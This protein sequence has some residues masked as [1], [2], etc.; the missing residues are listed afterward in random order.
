VLTSDTKVKL[1]WNDDDECATELAKDGCGYRTY[2]HPLCQ[3]IWQFLWVSKDSRLLVA[4]KEA[5]GLALLDDP[6]TTPVL[7]DW[8]SHIQA[9]LEEDDL[10]TALSGEG[11]DSAYLTASS[12]ELD[13][14]VRNGIRSGAL[15]IG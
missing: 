6:F 15:R 9:A 14:I 7:P 4:R 12:E 3:G 11:C 8:V 1:E 10:L 2:K 5:L 13:E